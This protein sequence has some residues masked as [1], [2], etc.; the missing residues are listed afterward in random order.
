MHKRGTRGGSAVTFM[1]TAVADDNFF[2]YLWNS[3]TA[4]GTTA[5][6]PPP[7]LPLRSV[8]ETPTA[9]EN[10]IDVAS[11]DR[12]L[13]ELLGELNTFLPAATADAAVSD[14]NP[15][16]DAAADCAVVGST[17]PTIPTP[18]S[19]VLQKIS[20]LKKT[21]RKTRATGCG[22]R[23]GQATLTVFA[24]G[25]DGDPNKFSVA[26]S[27]SRR[28]AAVATS[29]GNEVHNVI[30][31]NTSPDVHLSLL[32]EDPTTKAVN[33][34]ASNANCHLIIGA[35]ELSSLRFRERIGKS[36]LQRVPQD[37]EDFQ[38]ISDVVQT[39]VRKTSLIS[40]MQ[41]L[42]KWNDYNDSIQRV[43]DP[44]L[45]Y[46]QEMHTVFTADQRKGFLNALTMMMYI[47]LECMVSQ[48]KNA[49]GLV[50]NFAT[51]LGIDGFPLS[52]GSSIDKLTE[53]MVSVAST[54]EKPMALTEMGEEMVQN[55][56][57]IT[58]SILEYFTNGPMHKYLQHGKLI[59]CLGNKKEEVE[60]H[61]G[62][63][64]MS[65][66]TSSG[67]IVRYLHVKV[68]DPDPMYESDWIEIQSEPVSNESTLIDWKDQFNKQWSNF[69]DAFC[70]G[71]ASEED[72]ELW[73]ALSLEETGMGPVWTASP[74][75][76]E[77]LSLVDGE[78]T[79]SAMGAVGGN[80]KRPFGTLCSQ[81]SIQLKENDTHAITPT[82][83]W[84]TNNCTGP[85]V[86]WSVNTWCKNTS[87]HI[88]MHGNLH[89]RTISASSYIN[90]VKITL[91]TL[92]SHVVDHGQPYS[93]VWGD[94]K[95]TIGPVV[96]TAGVKEEWLRVVHWAPSQDIGVITL[97]PEAY[98]QYMLQDYN[99]ETRSDATSFSCGILSLPNAN[100]IP[101]VENV[102]GIEQD[103]A[104]ER[105]GLRIWKDISFTETLQNNSDVLRRMQS[106]LP[107]WKDFTS[108]RIDPTNT[109]PNPGEEF[110]TSPTHTSW[111]TST[112]SNDTLAGIVV[113]W[114]FA[115]ANAQM[116]TLAVDSGIDGDQAVYENVIRN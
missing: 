10:T 37:P 2:S 13:A 1:S 68:L 92:R 55:A 76:L 107:V 63:W 56:A 31:G 75:P 91:D 67:L 14:P 42:P 53:Q 82:S 12:D 26:L 46:T 88:E 71:T 81:L 18:H 15:N 104:R 39:L 7:P 47:K 5:T 93:R 51:R 74:L 25:G 103:A 99:Y 61:G 70:K 86:F 62:S 27:H 94:M 80:A 50:R 83:T 34:H 108:L 6:A 43:M 29:N 44:L 45:E 84:T 87:S 35:S 30:L 114:V 24:L 19:N 65:A 17:I 49:T 28:V 69:Y 73:T 38:A 59:E 36:E 101:I 16:P 89:D 11:L 64:F 115:E 106:A 100:S 112:S 66:G 95:G 98:I 21:V 48:T 23:N 102:T 8:A 9:S 57:Q 79:V 32:S 85:S 113:K 78:S 52:D 33:L 109:A 54:A 72:V 4:A 58:A 105:Y 111:Y 96:K 3:S 90:V 116:P 60:G 22:M 77:R 40:N 97:L 110:Q 20:P 41:F